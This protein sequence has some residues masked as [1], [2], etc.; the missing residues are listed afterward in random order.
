MGEDEDLFVFIDQDNE[1][2]ENLLSILSRETRENFILFSGYFLNYA[3]VM[4]FK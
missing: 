1:R 2:N 3:F 4:V